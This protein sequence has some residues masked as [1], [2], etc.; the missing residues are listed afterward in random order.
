MNF[1]TQ[2]IIKL[3]VRQNNVSYTCTNYQELVTISE[4][5]HFSQRSW[6]RSKCERAFRVSYRMASVGTICFLVLSCKQRKH[7]VSYGYVVLQ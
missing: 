7:L 6:L 2:Y 3:N 5:S 1:D 4:L